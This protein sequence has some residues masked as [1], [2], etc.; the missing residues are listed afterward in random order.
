MPEA[1][2]TRW[3]Q[4]LNMNMKKILNR[5]IHRRNFNNLSRRIRSWKEFQ[6]A[7]RFQGGQ[8]VLGPEHLALRR[9]MRRVKLV[10]QDGQ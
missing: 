9:S 7:D 3:V 5:I 10:Y 1:P 8:K 6:N 2:P 4:R